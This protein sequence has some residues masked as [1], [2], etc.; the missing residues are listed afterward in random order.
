ML[1]IWKS[2]GVLIEH[3]MEPVEPAWAIA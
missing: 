3:L 1:R 2:Y